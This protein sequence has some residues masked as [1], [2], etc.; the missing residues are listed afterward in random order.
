[1]IR[2]IF[3]SLPKNTPQKTTITNPTNKEEKRQKHNKVKNHLQKKNP[4]HSKLH[5][6]T[7]T[8]QLT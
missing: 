1:M 6:N 3:F 5:D 4:K 7:S 8:N 2:E